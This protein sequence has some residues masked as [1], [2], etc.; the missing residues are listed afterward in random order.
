MPIIPVHEDPLKTEERRRRLQKQDAIRKLEA[1]EKSGVALAR[2][3]FFVPGWAGE[4]GQA[5]TGYAAPVLAGHVAVKH[6]IERVVKNTERVTY[7]SYLEFSKKESAASKSFLDF[8]ELLK[9]R[10]RARVSGDEP[11]DLVGHSMGGLDIIA[12]I[13]QGPDAL[14]RVEH[15]VAVASPLRGIAYSRFVKRVDELLS[16]KERDIMEV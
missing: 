12:A 14:T 16:G 7:I 1:L 13:T 9:A 4:E 5:W 2:H 10:V 6:W 3:V 15:A 8:A 11:I